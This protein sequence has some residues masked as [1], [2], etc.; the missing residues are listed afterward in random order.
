MIKRTPDWRIW[1]GLG[2]TA[3]WLLLG[4]LYIAA[5]IGWSNFA[6]LPADELGSFLEGAFAPLAFLWL[7]IGYFLQQKELEQNTLALRA[8]AEE[9]QRTAEQAIIQSE[10]MAQSEMHARQEAFLQTSRIVRSQLSL[11]E[12]FLY[13]SSQAAL[14]SGAV[15]PE[16]Q[17]KLF[18]SGGRDSELFSRKIL[19]LQF[20]MD[21][22]A[23]QF[24]FFY[25]T[26]IRARHSNNI[27]FT[28]ERLIARAEAVDPD[29]MIRDALSTTGHG[30]VYRFAKRYQAMAPPE[31]ADPNATG[32]TVNF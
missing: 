15:T 3:G 14:A 18:A 25:G 12:G 30:L 32:L 4:T 8:Q 24:D 17:S 13:I 5:D 29:F 20:A 7:V 16:E 10:K 21:D 23:Q 9:I 6:H 28:F 26:P 27:I 1:L 31:L 11:I 22:P 2:L 19:E